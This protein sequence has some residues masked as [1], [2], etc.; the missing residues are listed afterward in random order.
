MASEVATVL[1]LPDAP[2]DLS[3]EIAASSTLDTVVINVSVTD[4]SPQRAAL[5]ANA[6]GQVFPDLVSQLK[7]P[8]DVNALPTVKA[9]VVQEAGIPTRPS[10]AGAG[11]CWGWVH[12][13]AAVGVLYANVR[14]ALRPAL[15]EPAGTNVAGAGHP[16]ADQTAAGAS[17]ANATVTA[18]GPRRRT[19]AGDPE[20]E[21]AGAACDLR[22][23]TLCPRPVRSRAVEWP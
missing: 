3:R 16:V 8:T 17:A 19:V 7:K 18:Q 15:S 2:D 6:V 20:H 9:S 12:L 23:A 14:N 22:D 11:T 1:N 21:R 10:S 5:I 13:R 4:R